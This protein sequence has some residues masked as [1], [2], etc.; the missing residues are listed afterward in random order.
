MAI[1]FDAARADR[2]NGGSDGVNAGVVVGSG[3]DNH[4]LNPGVRLTW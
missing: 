1:A 3:T 2:G 4:T